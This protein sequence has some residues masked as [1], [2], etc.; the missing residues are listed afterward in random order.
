MTSEQQL[1]ADAEGGLAL[2]TDAGRLR[3]RLQ[4]L[5]RIDLDAVTGADADRPL[6]VMANLVPTQTPSHRLSPPEPRPMGSEDWI[7]SPPA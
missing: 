6:S 2:D 3:Q 1:L 4:R 7:A 5:V